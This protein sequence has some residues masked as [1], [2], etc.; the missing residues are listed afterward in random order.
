MA[1]SLQHEELGEIMNLIKGIYYR[2]LHDYLTIKHFK[3]ISLAIFWLF[4]GIIILSVVCSGAMYV[5]SYSYQFIGDFFKSS[6]ESN[7][8]E[9]V[10]KLVLLEFPSKVF[11]S[12]ISFGIYLC[13]ITTVFRLKKIV[14]NIKNWAVDVANYGK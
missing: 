9:A 13:L 10:Q 12:L 11:G 3:Q 2:Y 1:L 8:S 7:S 14:K 5:I 4:V 6:I